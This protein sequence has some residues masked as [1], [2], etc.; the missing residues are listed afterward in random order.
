MKKK[1]D[2][3]YSED[4]REAQEKFNDLL[5]SCVL[6]A[7]LSI[8]NEENNCIFLNNKFKNLSISN[9]DKILFRSKEYLIYIDKK[10]RIIGS[11]SFVN[12]FNITY[13][14]RVVMEVI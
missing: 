5:K 1:K 11:V 2:I 8:S 10:G 6:N 14:Q 9:E 13:I 4:K 3:Y 12:N 7:Y